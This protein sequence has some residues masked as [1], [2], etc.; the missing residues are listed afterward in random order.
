MSLETVLDGTLLQEDGVPTTSATYSGV[1]STE[2]N[3][4]HEEINVDVDGGT[5]VSSALSSQNP[6]IDFTSG[7]VSGTADDLASFIPT[8]VANSSV[9]T[10]TTTG[11]GHNWSY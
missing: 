1:A 10:F 4:N 11:T 5:A 2:G 9:F 7:T 6:T 3:I 8:S